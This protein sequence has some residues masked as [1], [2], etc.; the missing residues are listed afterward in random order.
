MRDDALTV[1]AKNKW[2]RHVKGTFYYRKKDIKYFLQNTHYTYL[3]HRNYYTR[4][5]L[6]QCEIIDKEST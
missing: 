4:L 5:Q 3:L 6:L 2:I 1:K